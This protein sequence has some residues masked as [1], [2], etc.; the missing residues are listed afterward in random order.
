MPY[1]ACILALFQTTSYNV[2]SQAVSVSYTQ[3][4]IRSLLLFYNARIS[5]YYL[6]GVSLRLE[7]NKYN[8]IYRTH[9]ATEKHNK[10]YLFFTQSTI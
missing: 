5:N 6:G 7:A 10:S 2:T 3:A 4:S 1:E 8:E 9:P